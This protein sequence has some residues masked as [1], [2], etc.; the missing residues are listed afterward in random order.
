MSVAEPYLS[1]AKA[2]ASAEYVLPPKPDDADWVLE[3][4][5]TKYVYEPDGSGYHVSVPNIDED[6]CVVL[7]VETMPNCSEYAIL[8]VAASKSAWYAWISPWILGLSSS[9][10]HLI[11]LSP[12]NTTQARLTIGHNISYDR[13]RI[14]EEYRID[15]TKGRFLD[16][17]AM[18][19]AIKGISSHQ[20][21]AWMKRRKERERERERKEEAVRAV[22]SVVVMLEEA[23]ESLLVGEGGGVEEKKNGKVDEQ[24]EGI[25]RMRIQMK[26][27]LPQLRAQAE[28][29]ESSAGLEEE[30]E[31][32]TP[33]RWEDITSTNSLAAVA[34]LHCSIHLP[35]ET[36]SDFMTHTPSQIFSSLPTYLSYCA[37]DVYATHQVHK[38]VLPAF[39]GKCP[40]PVS[41]AGVGVMGSGFL[42]V[43]ESW[44][45]YLKKAEG[46]YRQLEGEVKGRLKELA[47]MTRD[48]GLERSAAREEDPWLGQLDW[49][50]KEVRK[51]RGVGIEPVNEVFLGLFYVCITSI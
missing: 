28:A 19:I 49:G 32:E 8:A 48:I 17:M 16:T 2:M 25:R 33:K 20:R 51:S 42:C 44:E 13:A 37:N 1:M 22:E 24:I 35:K 7:D 14:M 34:A 41:F 21:G 31:G 12:N 6:Q 4:G 38:K 5:W 46:K 27:S 40:S 36:R 39:L 3:P 9:P 29:L 43:D 30:T 15:G 10:K 50:L 23:E 11:P 47:V 26:E 45:E 18:H